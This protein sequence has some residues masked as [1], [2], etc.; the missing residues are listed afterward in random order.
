MYTVAK[1]KEKGYS[2][3]LCATETEIPCDL[4]QVQVK[5]LRE[6]VVALW[7]N[8]RGHG[9]EAM[10]SPFHSIL[11]GVRA[12]KQQNQSCKHKGKGYVKD[13]SIKTITA[14]ESMV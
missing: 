6:I 12:T 4:Q 11:M 1:K 9:P 3:P 8:S 2:T 13:F 10:F 5:Q 14:N 7:L